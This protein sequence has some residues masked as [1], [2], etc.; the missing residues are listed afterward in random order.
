MQ[1]RGAWSGPSITESIGLL[2]ARAADDAGIGGRS[3]V[4]PASID[5]GGGIHSGDGRGS[6]SIPEG[7]GGRAGPDRS[8]S[9]E[10]S[11]GGAGER[12]CDPGHLHAAS[13]GRRAGGPEAGRP[14]GAQLFSRSIAA[15]CRRTRARMAAGATAAAAWRPSRISDR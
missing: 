15:G 13:A 10:H 14:A 5:G 1:Q 8:R 9:I 7:R 3:D 11:A 12:C 6:R 2:P 4:R